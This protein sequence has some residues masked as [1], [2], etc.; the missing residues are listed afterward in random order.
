[1]PVARRCPIATVFPAE[2]ILSINIESDRRLVPRVKVDHEVTV[3][4]DVSLLDANIIDR[5]QLPLT[6]VGRTR[7]LSLR[8][9]SL[10]LPSIRADERYPT[11]AAPT[12]NV[13]L[14]LPVGSV[15]LRAA[16]V[17]AKPVTERDPYRASVIG[18]CIAEI[19]KRDHEL[20]EHYLSKLS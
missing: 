12:M 2:A 10:I 11:V 3:L 19:S 18:L 6:L 5:L 1:M 7:D 13:T 9:L 20:L 15:A 16:A 4:A 14:D 17:Y 8:G